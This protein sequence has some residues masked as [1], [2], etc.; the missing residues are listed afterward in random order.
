MATFNRVTDR[1]CRLVIIFF[2]GTLSA[3]Q[4][5]GGH[6]NPADP[7]FG[8][9]KQKTGQAAIMPRTPH[10]DKKVWIQV[11]NGF[12]AIHRL[13]FSAVLEMCQMGLARSLLFKTFRTITQAGLKKEAFLSTLGSHVFLNNCSKG[14]CPHG[15]S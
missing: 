7:T 5:D 12:T 11:H 4:S 6:C 9:F 15:T 2:A 3:D 13:V 10:G 8:L 14:L 1:A